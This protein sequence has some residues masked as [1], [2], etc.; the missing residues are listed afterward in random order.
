MMMTWQ[1]HYYRL[2]YVVLSK[3]YN[4]KALS[5]SAKLS[6]RRYVTQQEVG[7][8]MERLLKVSAPFLACRLGTG[9]AF[10]MRTFHFRH[11]KNQQKVTEQLCS[12]AG[13]FPP[14]HKYMIQF[15]E[16]MENDLREAD[17]FG[18]AYE[19]LVDFFISNYVS[20]QAFI[21]DIG[22]IVPI[23]ME[24]PWTRQ[25]EGKKVLVI[26]PFAQTI[27]EQYQKRKKLF[28]NQEVLPEFELLT[29][30]AVQT[31]AG[32]RDERFN[33]WF[34]ALN[35]MKEEIGQMEYD[36]ALLGCGAYGLPLAAWI[37]R[38]G[39]QAVHIGGALQLLFGIKGKRWDNMVEVNGLY[40]EYWV[41]PSREET[42]DGADMVEGGCYWGGEES[43]SSV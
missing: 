19:P 7:R 40:N 23:A 15:T 22:S 29:Y 36:V 27:Q 37:K 25:L 28:E 18:T 26:H 2:K 13:F 4:D 35:Y 5:K 32:V 41:Y 11:E 20:K 39:K 31:S 9:E 3:L 43:E 17:L 12:C 21:M 6:G 34:E 14:E 42:P 8:E 24:H 33:S 30:R 10:A 1:W 38:Q 16:Q